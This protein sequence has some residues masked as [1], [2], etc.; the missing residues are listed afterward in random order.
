[1]VRTCSIM[2]RI[3]WIIRVLCW[4]GRFAADEA[5]DLL[6]VCAVRGHRAPFAKDREGDLV[7]VGKLER[8]VRSTRNLLE[9]VE[10]T[11]NAG[12]RFQSLSAPWADTTR[13]AGKMMMTIFAGI[14]EFELDLKRER[15]GAGRADAQ[16]RGVR[17]GRP[18][19]M[20]SEQQNLAKRLLKEGNSVSELA[21]SVSVL[22]PYTESF[23]QCGT[24]WGCQ[25][26]RS[27]IGG[28][29]LCS[30][31]SLYW[32]YSHLSATIGST[33]IARRDGSHAAINATARNKS[34]IPANGTLS[35][36][37]R[38]CSSPRSK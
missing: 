1:M 24:N 4:R 5:T 29:R 20:N 22:P 15:T 37:L 11:G 26:P 35:T 13:H 2:D 3:C 18:E 8:L 33:R 25:F 17:F 23:R 30:V 28:K 6:V 12:A 27:I 14:A 7:A 21:P 38:P 36:V 32:S 16:K 31:V 19:E 10:M 9:S 34:E